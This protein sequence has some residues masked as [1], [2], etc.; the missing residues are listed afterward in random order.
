MELNWIEQL[1][2]GGPVMIPIGMLSVLGLMSV[3]ERAWM[4][5]R[6]RAEGKLTL[7]HK[8]LQTM[9]QSD[10]RLLIED[11]GRQL[12]G[13]LHK[14]T[15][16]LGITASV[17]PM[18]GLLGT[19]LGMIVTFSEIQHVGV[20]DAGALAGGISQALVTTFAGLCVGIPALVAHRWVLR[21]IDDIALDWEEY[22]RGQVEESS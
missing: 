15:F 5:P 12:V 14:K 3:L 11:V 21:E 17:A 22:C 4:L 9:A 7:Q 2:A 18:L 13:A 6:S 8:I 19:V 10:Q 16:L 20:G 1:Q